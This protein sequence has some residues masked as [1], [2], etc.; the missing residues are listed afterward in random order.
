MNRMDGNLRR[1]SF[2]GGVGLTM[3][4]MVGWLG[5]PSAAWAEAER[6]EPTGYDLVIYGGTSAGVMA[7]V[8]GS[9]LGL[10]VVLKLPSG[11]ED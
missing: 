5:W 1:C 9:R 6:R 4:L 10:S 8:T 7:A 3:A 2:A 11:L